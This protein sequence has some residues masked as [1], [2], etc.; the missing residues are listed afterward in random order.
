MRKHHPKPPPR[1]LGAEGLVRFRT[2]TT[3]HNA[4]TPI[5][6]LEKEISRNLGSAG[7][8]KRFIFVKLLILPHY[9]LT[10]LHTYI[11]IYIYLNGVLDSL[12][13]VRT[14]VRIWTFRK[15]RFVAL[16]LQCHVKRCDCCEGTSLCFS[17][18]RLEAVLGLLSTALAVQCVCPKWLIYTGN[19]PSVD[20][21]VTW[22]Q[23][24]L[25][26]QTY[27]C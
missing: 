2:T 27:I 23:W 19:L 26:L 15:R 17:S 25:A 22:A 7:S 12:C 9:I 18:R 21:L 4:F 14:L 20:V 8:L 6:G 1:R 16:C 13:Y 11:F 5:H 24:W 10:C 3:L